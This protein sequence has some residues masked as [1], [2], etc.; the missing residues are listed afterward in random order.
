MKD[1]LFFERSVAN[2]SMNGKVTG[3]IHYFSWL[4]PLGPDKQWVPWLNVEWN[5]SSN[6]R[7]E[8]DSLWIH[9]YAMQQGYLKATPVQLKLLIK[10]SFSAKKIKRTGLSD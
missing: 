1:I 10:L 7:Y 3:M 2:T 9:P 5:M 6:N 8:K 4:L